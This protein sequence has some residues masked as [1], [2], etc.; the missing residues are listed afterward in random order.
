LS[1][2]GQKVLYIVCYNDALTAISS[3]RSLPV[4]CGYASHGSSKGKIGNL[5]Q[6]AYLEHPHPLK[7]ALMA[8]L[9]YLFS[10]TFCQEHRLSQPDH[11]KRVFSLQV[12]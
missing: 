2:K 12:K 6:L 7:A 8:L 1:L 4:N 11:S 9:L 5:E 3:S 10:V